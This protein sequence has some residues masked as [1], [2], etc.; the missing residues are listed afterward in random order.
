M[1]YEDKKE[2]E[3]LKADWLE[4]PCWDIETTEG[5]EDHK[6]ELKTF[7]DEQKTKWKAEWDKKVAEY[8]KRHSI[9]NPFV[10]ERLFTIEMNL[11][12]ID[13]LLIDIMDNIKNGLK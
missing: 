2:I 5:F 12:R 3:D 7:A 1:N 13:Q 10:A 4:D 8:G 9:A 11:S 6:E